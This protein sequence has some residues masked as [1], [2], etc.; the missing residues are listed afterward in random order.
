[1]D[2][3]PSLPCWSILWP[4]IQLETETTLEV[5]GHFHGELEV[6]AVVRIT[7]MMRRWD[8]SE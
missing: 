8:P 1:M 3:V 2:P 4:P 7:S 6:I 5:N